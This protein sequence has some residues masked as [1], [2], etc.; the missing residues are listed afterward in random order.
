MLEEI[1]MRK[2]LLIFISFIVVFPVLAQEE[3]LY[4]IV[5]PYE[6]ARESA[7]EIW[8]KDFSENATPQELLSLGLIGV[9][10]LKDKEDEIEKME[11]KESLICTFCG[12]SE[13]ITPNTWDDYKYKQKLTPICKKYVEL[14]AEAQKL[15]SDEDIEREKKRNSPMGL[16]KKKCNQDFSKW[17]V[18]SEFEKNIEW[19]NRIQS[20]GN[21][22]FDSICSSYYLSSWHNAK[23]AFNN[24]DA[25]TESFSLTL[26]YYNQGKEVSSLTGYC[27][28]K[29]NPQ[30]AK[31]F[32]KDHE[33]YINSFDCEGKLMNV[34]GYIYPKRVTI[35]N[36]YTFIF[37]IPDNAQDV[38]VCNNIT[39]YC[40]DSQRW[41]KISDSLQYLQHI[42]DSLEILR[43][44]VNIKKSQ[45]LDSLKLYRYF[46]SDSSYKRYCNVYKE[47]LEDKNG[48][49]LMGAD[50]AF[51]NMVPRIL[52]E[53]YGAL[54]YLF[55]NQSEF[56]QFFKT[57]YSHP[58]P[59]VV[60]RQLKEMSIQRLHVELIKSNLKDGS[61][62]HNNPSH[63]LAK[64]IVSYINAIRFYDKMGVI[65]EKIS[66]SKLL[67]FTFSFS[68][69]EYVDIIELHDWADNY[70]YLR[71]GIKQ[72]Y[73]EDYGLYVFDFFLEYINGN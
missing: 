54:Q 73:R 3:N 67:P 47:I 52:L 5:T 42:T 14:I 64:E 70:K 1:I 34:N 69:E 22:K 33:S 7:S 46:S 25:E 36:T 28:V 2:L 56:Y 45:L 49:D 38:V 32:L 31:K 44:N 68:Y 8:L 40:F 26:T 20:K 24:Y 13:I 9:L 27:V 37:P 53:H 23:P 65:K 39:G 55:E 60:F 18:K 4:Q 62:L 41:K 10:E 16:L 35:G 66:R 57:F 17:A 50:T 72:S 19:S 48:Y 6:K 15:K 71:K 63:P 61:E 21:F 58:N 30:F 43:K 12:L 59:S 51:T 11:A 29:D